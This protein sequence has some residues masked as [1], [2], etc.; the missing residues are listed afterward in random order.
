[1]T[2]KRSV[3]ATAGLLLLCAAV[4]TAAASAATRNPTHAAG[5]TNGVSDRINGRVVCGHVGGKCL[6]AHNA[7]YRARGYTCVNG[8]LK[9]IKRPRSRS[10]TPLPPKETRVRRRSRCP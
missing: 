5:C 8:R 6:A 10:V 4:V 7:A 3:V 2:F 1:M 9:R